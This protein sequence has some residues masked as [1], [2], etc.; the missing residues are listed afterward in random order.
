LAAAADA[1]AQNAIH[2]ARSLV[3]GSF[4]ATSAHASRRAGIDQQSLFA[5]QINEFSELFEAKMHD[6]AGPVHN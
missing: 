4:L 5:S 6:F 2:A 1:S 3:I